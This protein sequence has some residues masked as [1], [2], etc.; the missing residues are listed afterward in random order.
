MED[1][2][3]EINLPRFELKDLPTLIAAGDG[4]Y[5]MHLTK[6]VRAEGE[7]SRASMDAMLKAISGEVS[8][9]FESVR[10]GAML[11]V[12][13]YQREYRRRIERFDTSEVLMPNVSLSQVL[14]QQLMLCKSTHHDAPSVCYVLP[15]R[16]TPKFVCRVDHDD[17]DREQFVA[18]FA[19]DEDYMVRYKMHRDVFICIHTMPNRHVAGVSL[20]NEHGDSFE[21]YHQGVSSLT[22]LGNNS[23]PVNTINSVGDAVEIR[24]YMQ[25]LLSTVNMDSLY[26]ERPYGY[27]YAFDLE[28]NSRE[29]DGW[30]QDTVVSRG[31]RVVT[32][33]HVASWSTAL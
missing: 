21:H 14:G 6:V 11:V 29:I 7:S 24:N 8:N 9:R 2:T 18:K 4:V 32:E 31:E 1:T 16:Y 5:R 13:G 26:S 23:L 15:F 19:I 17:N 10:E 3:E 25:E 28:D 30:N 22:C 12:Q 33:E 20:V 27:P